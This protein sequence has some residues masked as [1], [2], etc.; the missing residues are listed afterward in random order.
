MTEIL[1][2]KEAPFIIHQ[3]RY[4]MFSRALLE[5]DLS[6]VLEEEGLGAITFSPLAQG[7]L[8]NRY[9][10][11]I[12]EDSRDIVRKYHS[13]QKNKLDQLWKKSKHCK[14]SPYHEDN[15]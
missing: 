2:R 1:K 10:H 12:P 8:T 3:M 11:G 4:N 6:P 15:H 5:D 7:L 14:Q 9:L 13:F